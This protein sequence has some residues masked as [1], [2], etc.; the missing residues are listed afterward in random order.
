MEV[1]TGRPVDIIM[2]A[3]CLKCDFKVRNDF[4]TN[5]TCQFGLF[6]GASGDMEKYNAL[7]LFNRSMAIGFRYT[8]YV[9]DGDCKNHA[10]IVDSQPYGE[11]VE[12]F[13]L[14]CANHLGKRCYKKLEKFGNSWTGNK[15]KEVDSGKG[16][17]KDS[18]KGGAKKK[19]KENAREKE[20]KERAIGKHGVDITGYYWAS[21][22]QEGTSGGQE[23]K[24]VGQGPSSA[25]GKSGG[26]G[27][28]AKNSG[29][30][31]G[32][33]S[34]DNV[35]TE[36]VVPLSSE[37]NINVPIGDKPIP[38]D[39]GID[40]SQ[41]TETPLELVIPPLVK[42]TVPRTNSRLAR[43][44]KKAGTTPSV[45]TLF[46]LAK[47]DSSLDVSST[48]S[49]QNVQVD[50]ETSTVS[51]PGLPEQPEEEA[52]TSRRS[53]RITSKSRPNYNQG[54][55]SSEEVEVLEAASTPVVPEVASSAGLA[56]AST[57]GQAD[58]SASPASFDVPQWLKDRHD[59]PRRTYVIKHM[60]TGIL[61]NRIARKY[62][63]AVYSHCDD[64]PAIQ[65]RAVRG[66][67]NHELD[68]K[69]TTGDQRKH[70]HRFCDAG[71][72]FNKWL[73]TG[74]T[75]QTYCKTTYKDFAGKEVPWDSGVFAGMDSIF[76]EAFREL[77][78]IFEVIGDQSLMSRC[79][80]VRTQNINESI[81]AKIWA[82]CSKHK[83]HKHARFIFAAQQVVLNHNLGIFGASLLNVL[84]LV[85]PEVAKGLQGL[86][87][88]SL[89]SAERKWVIGPTVSKLNR[90]KVRT[91]GAANELARPLPS[92]TGAS[93]SSRSTR[94]STRGRRTS[95]RASGA[96]CA[97]D[98]I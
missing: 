48:Q 3:K 85:S 34:I 59:N 95:G 74:G 14:E 11:G 63:L 30:K 88:R 31:G 45:L 60:F 93:S 6:H 65:S 87:C 27:G 75:A 40:L 66:V 77:E 80:T 20:D 79:S 86:D 49:S 90:R 71:C 98:E 73:A 35:S 72:G 32:V 15:D 91:K 61:C 38:A 5:G 26:K 46:P 28:K 50:Q 9:G 22:S 84:G 25:K 4:S 64:G 42:K 7:Q 13:K 97:G 55:S 16:S 1:Y 36:S 83:M 10:A 18:D 43:A 17:G 89:R 51:S 44:Q 2:S 78:E 57:P 37:L 24:S 29:T 81:H 33:K 58:P 82:I 39:Y 19:A 68:H 62:R 70:Y 41:V 92:R 94:S 47:K 53:G 69:D 54:G 96:Y 23:G 12:I 76:P 67:L 8:S 52:V 21:G 56:A